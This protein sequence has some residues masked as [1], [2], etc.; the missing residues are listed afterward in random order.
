M[1]RHIHSKKVA[2]LGYLISFHYAN[3]IYSLD[4][5]VIEECGSSLQGQKIQ[6]YGLAL[7]LF[8]SI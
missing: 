1:L 7:N 5:A 8:N 4:Y 6:L 3:G 2:R